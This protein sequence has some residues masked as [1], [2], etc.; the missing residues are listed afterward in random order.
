MN[1]QLDED[2]KPPPEAVMLRNCMTA[3]YS[4]G[5]ATAVRVR[6]IQRV[7]CVAYG[8]LTLTSAIL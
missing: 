1:A 3:A 2:W 7:N 6:S 4:S 5:V 8:A